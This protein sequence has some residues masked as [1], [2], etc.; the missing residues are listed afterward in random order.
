MPSRSR[1]VTRQVRAGIPGEDNSFALFSPGRG[2]P[3]ALLEVAADSLDWPAPMQGVS[4]P[5]EV[6]LSFALTNF[7][8]GE[9][10]GGQLAD[11]FLAIADLNVYRY[12]FDC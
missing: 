6:V 11:D 5:L 8:I 3:Y 7:Q 1:N 2:R 12:Q 9:S 10:K 4:R